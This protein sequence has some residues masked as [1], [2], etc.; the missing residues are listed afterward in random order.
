[1]PTAGSN[2]KLQNPNPKQYQNS[3]T[4]NVA[5]ARLELW[6]LELIWNLRFGTRHVSLHRTGRT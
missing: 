2:S 4:V 1:M 5:A 6:P 3:N